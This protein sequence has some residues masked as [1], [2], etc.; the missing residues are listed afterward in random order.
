MP[1]VEIVD[2][3]EV[4]RELRLG[5]EAA[6][7]AARASAGEARTSLE[8]TIL[9]PTLES[10]ILENYRGGDQ[11]LLFLNRRGFAR[12]IQ[13]ES[14]GKVETC[15]H[16][17]VSLTEHRGRRVAVCHHCGFTRAPAQRCS[18]CGSALLPRLR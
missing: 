13:C 5:G 9:S 18:E 15:P 7:D 11:T 14:C 2:L 4:R 10:A 3:R 6:A 17:S 1:T 8:P 12:F 16:C